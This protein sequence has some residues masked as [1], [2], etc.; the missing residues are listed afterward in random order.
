MKALRPL[1]I[2]STYRCARPLSVPRSRERRIQDVPRVGSVSGLEQ[3][4]VR[5]RLGY[6]AV[7]DSPRDDEEF[8]WTDLH[9]TIAEL[10]REAALD[11]QE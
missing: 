8:A 3:Q 2:K 6:S 11:A 4:H 9:R 1:E 10:H 7:L 5:L